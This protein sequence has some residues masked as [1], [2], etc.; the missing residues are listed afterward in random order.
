MGLHLIKIRAK[1]SHHLKLEFLTFGWGSLKKGWCGRSWS[2]CSWIWAHIKA[3]CLC[4]DVTLNPVTSMLLQPLWTLLLGHASL[5]CS[6]LFPVGFSLVSFLSCSA[7]FLLLDLLCFRCAS[8][9]R[10][11]LQPDSSVSWSTVS[12]CLTLTLY[13]HMVFIFPLTVLH[14]YL[15]PVHLPQEAP[16]LPLL[17]AQVLACLLLFDFQSFMWHLVHHRVSWLYRQFHKVCIWKPWPDQ[18]IISEYC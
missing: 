16:P 3:G 17:V 4:A 1:L 11:K 2:R 12:S 7:P 18:S 15:R 10:Y 13:N 5:L 14:W 9:R 6:P 8:V